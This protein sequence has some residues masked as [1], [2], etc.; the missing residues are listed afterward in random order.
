MPIPMNT[1]CIE[2]FL[3]KRLA[4]IRQLGSEQE[5]M[6]IG[7]MLM[8]EFSQAPEDMDS[9]LLS[10][11]ADQIIN[12]HYG[13]DPDRMRQEKQLSN[14]FVLDRL[15]D[16]R[17]R[18]SQ[19]QDPLYAALQFAVLG[20]YLDFS[21]L[22]GQVSFEDLDKMLDSALDM[23]LDRDCYRQF[24]SDLKNGKNFLYITDNAGEICFDRVLAEVIAQQYPQLAITFCVRGYPVSNDAT[25]EDAA[26]AG[27]QFPMIDSG[28]AIGGTVIS[29][30]NAETKEALA[31]A[32]VILAKGMGNTETMFGCG[33]N[34][35][36]A[37]LVK[38][39][40]F[41]EFFDAP[42]MK[43]MFIRDHK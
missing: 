1:T 22:Y 31:S 27:I 13:I 25:R 8:Q 11:I 26:V 24:L 28:T 17:N 15:T 5:A 19:A 9:A 34:V 12:S 6:A 7:K 30:V 35:Y 20:N 18:I 23:E 10:A 21:A 33:Y 3:S 37:F 41:M 38:C 36:Y 43:P 32:D 42:K 4:Q 14:Q 29:R 40:R 2:C 16:I 39:Q